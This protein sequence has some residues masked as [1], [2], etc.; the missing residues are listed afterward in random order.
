MEFTNITK[1]TTGYKAFV[2]HHKACNSINRRLRQ[3]KDGK[4]LYTFN[5]G[6]EGIFLFKEQDYLFVKSVLSNYKCLDA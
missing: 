3:F 4:S 5:D 2:T 6:E 1:T